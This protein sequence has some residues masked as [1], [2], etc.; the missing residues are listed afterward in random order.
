MLNIGV[1][2]AGSEQYYLGSVARGG[3]DY[4]V[5]GEVPGRWLGHGSEQLGLAGEVDGTDLAA[6]LADRDPGSGTRLGCAANRKVPGFDLTF[7]TQ[8]S[9]SVLLGLGDRDVAGAVRLAHEEAVDA[10]VGYL[11]RDAVWSRRGRNGVDA[12]PGDGL[13]GAAFRHRTDR[14]GDPHLHTHV[15]VANTVR[16]PDGQWR[17]LDFR[18]VFAH[19]KTAGYLY[20]AHLRHLLT[21]RLGVEWR[22][23]RNG[24]AEL[25][26]IPDDVRRR[27]STR[28]AVVE[29]ALEA[30]GERSARAAQIA[31]LETRRPKERDVEAGHLRARW[32]EAA[33]AIG[34]DPKELDQL[35]DRRKR[36]ARGRG[37][38]IPGRATPGRSTGARRAASTF[39]RVAVLRAWWDQLPTGGSINEIERLADRF[40]AEHHD[41]VPLH[42]VG[43][44]SLRGADGRVLSTVSTGGRWSTAELLVLEHR[45]LT[46]ATAT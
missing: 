14:A 2:A 10:A 7:S 11:E 13:I 27:F 6:V 44:A 5:G 45:L 40:L 22:P 35:L 26:G 8:K 19:G 28:R 21:D 32:A 20:E 42:D 4:Y 41:V 30:R 38:S 24:T 16:G 36:E 37:P 9:V 12:V 17:T 1:L 23:V 31:T 15:L 29:A 43:T 3:E 33:S 25:A 18:H 39:D 46:D 34:F